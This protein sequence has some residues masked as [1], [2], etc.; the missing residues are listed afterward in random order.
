MTNNILLALILKSNL[1]FCILSL[2][3][4]NR[5]IRINQNDSEIQIIIYYRGTV[6]VHD[7]RAY[8]IVRT[9]TYVLHLVAS[10]KE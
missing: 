1:V 5:C 2:L 10:I 3:N 8:S 4:S 7:M 6:C 9:R